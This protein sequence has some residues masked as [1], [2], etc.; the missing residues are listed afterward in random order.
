M[1]SRTAPFIGIR[2]RRTN[3]LCRAKSSWCRPNARNVLVAEVGDSSA[4]ARRSRGRIALLMP[5]MPDDG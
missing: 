4:R 2:Y 3:V 1:P 5:Q